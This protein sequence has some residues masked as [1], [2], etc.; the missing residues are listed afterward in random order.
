M[1]TIRASSE[2]PFRLIGTFIQYLLLLCFALHINI[3]A[4]RETKS[5]PFLYFSKIYLCF[6]ITLPLLQS[7]EIQQ[8]FMAN[9]L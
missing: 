1:R 7:D 9:Q 8:S 6:N 5:Q 4:E 2:F 3:K